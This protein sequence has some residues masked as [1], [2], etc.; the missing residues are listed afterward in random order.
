MDYVNLISLN[1]K[2][3]IYILIST[4]LLGLRLSFV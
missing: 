1:I 3:D 4:P 2:K